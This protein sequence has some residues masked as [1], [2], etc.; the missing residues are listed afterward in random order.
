MNILSYIQARLKAP[1]GQFNKFGNYKYRSCED[2][3]EAVKPLL[4]EHDLALVINDDIVSVSERVYVKATV[5]I[6]DGEKVLYTAS[7]FA[8]E[9][10]TKKGMDEAQITGATSSYSRKYALNALF[11]IDDTK[12]A[13][14][15]DNRIDN[16]VEPRLDYIEKA[17]KVYQEEI[18]KEIY[19]E[20]GDYNKVKQVNHYLTNDERI[21]VE[22]LFGTETVPGGKKQLKTILRELIAKTE[23]DEEI[24]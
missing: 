18:E 9:P 24:L 16:T 7:A 19:E 8:R 10:L 1:K 15:M 21:A 5:S 14:T 22:K 2:I 13:D 12:D 3:I 20:N 6:T 17:Y 23:A 11:A 4:H